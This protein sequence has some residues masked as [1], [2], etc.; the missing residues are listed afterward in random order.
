MPLEKESYR[1]NLELLLKEF[2]D[3]KDLMCNEFAK[4][5]G[6]DRKHVSKRYGF[7][8]KNKYQSLATL[9]RKMS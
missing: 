2:P 6:R 7:D 4:Y 5:L 1:D 3:K 8:R 9:A